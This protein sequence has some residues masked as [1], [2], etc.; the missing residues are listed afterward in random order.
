MNLTLALMIGFDRLARI[1]Q[2]QWAEIRQPGGRDV[3][4]IILGNVTHWIGLVQR[5]HIIN[6]AERF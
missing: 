5:R 4:E 6:R 3:Q 2:R 1:K